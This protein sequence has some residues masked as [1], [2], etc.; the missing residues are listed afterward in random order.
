M[1]KKILVVIGLLLQIFGFIASNADR[2]SSYRNMI[3]PYH[4]KFIY[5]LRSLQNGIKVT[6]SDPLFW[7]YVQFLQ[8]EKGDLKDCQIAQIDALSCNPSLNMDGEHMHCNFSITLANGESRQVDVR[9]LQEKTDEYLLKNP[10]FNIAKYCFWLGVLLEVIACIL[11]FFETR[12]GRSF[13]VIKAKS[14]RKIKR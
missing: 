8:N 1:F 5:S 10:A 2:D 3:V 7:I 4:D 9:D 13:K 14:K 6:A 12:N 11:A